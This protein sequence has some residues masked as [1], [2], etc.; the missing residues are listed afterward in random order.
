MFNY[1]SA[2]EYYFTLLLRYIRKHPK[3]EFYC[4]DNISTYMQKKNVNT[5]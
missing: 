2:F 5:K 4:K 3:T 1:I